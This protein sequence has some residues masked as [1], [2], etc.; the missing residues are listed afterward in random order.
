MMGSYNTKCI[1]CS[2]IITADSDIEISCMCYDCRREVEKQIEAGVFPEGI[3]DTAKKYFTLVRWIRLK[4]IE[5]DTRQKVPKSLEDAKRLEYEGIQK[6]QDAIAK[7][8]YEA[9]SY[10]RQEK[11]ARDGEKYTGYMQDFKLPL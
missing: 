3:S 2:K 1:R 9:Q 7:F 10:A 4:K 6:Y 8:N 5:I 11:E